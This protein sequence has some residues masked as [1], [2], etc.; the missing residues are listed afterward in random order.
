MT[1]ANRYR[2]RGSRRGAGQYD[3]TYR[4]LRAELLKGDPCCHW[5]GAPAQVADHLL[6]LSQGGTNE[7][8]NLVPACYRCNNARARKG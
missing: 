3:R 4:R 7:A 5:C 2:T 8:T 6:P 1:E